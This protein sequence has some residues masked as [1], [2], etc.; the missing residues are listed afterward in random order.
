MSVPARLQMD[1][2]GGRIAARLA[3]LAALTDDP[4]VITRLYLSPAHRRAADLVSL[5]MRD[6]GMSVRMDP[7]GTVVG[8]LDG[9]EP[10]APVLYLGSHIDTV[11]NAGAYD[12]NFG[13]VAAIEAVAALRAARRQ[14]PLAI[15]VLAFGDEEGVRFS[16]T[17]TGSRA[18]AG[19]WNPAVLDEADDDGSQ[20]IRWRSGASARASATS[21][22][23]LSRGRCWSAR[24]CH[25]AS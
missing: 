16:T 15:E 12:G 6:A 22:R 21:R 5:W 25:S 14:L 20:P 18:V 3:A 10:D 11:R 7:L 8:R 9:P 19:R 2:G 23:I 4:G 17:L 1:S 13:V 24:T